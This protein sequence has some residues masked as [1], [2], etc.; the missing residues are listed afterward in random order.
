MSDT[1]RE[2][3]APAAEPGKAQ[4][5]VAQAVAGSP[6][7]PENAE[8]VGKAGET[9][10][11]AAQPDVEELQR[12]LEEVRNKADE[13]WS[14]VLRAKAELENLRKRHEREIE[15]ARKFAL[16][17]FVGELLQVWDSLELGVLA[18]QEDKADVAKLREGSELT[19]KLL[20]GAMTKFGVEQLDPDGQPFNPDFHQA[21][22]VQPRDDVPPNTVV[23]VMQK[24]YILN[25][26]LV[27]PA[28]VM[29][30][31]SAA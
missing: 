18:A 5:A 24:G 10:Q 27:R 26:R 31:Q 2:E 20:Q 4:E 21:M 29:V 28:L 17:G 19:L 25:G 23:S 12:L 11:A 13:N 9:G 22:S 1:K 30:S 7:A 6:E 14:Q 16:E 3:A 15:A 8:A